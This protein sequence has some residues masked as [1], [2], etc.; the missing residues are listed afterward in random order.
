MTAHLGVL[1]GQRAQ[2]GHNLIRATV[3]WDRFPVRHAGDDR[4]YKA[5]AVIAAILDPGVIAAL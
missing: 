4:R 3:Q 5:F 1:L 2:F